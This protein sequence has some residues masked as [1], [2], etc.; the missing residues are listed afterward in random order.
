[1]AETESWWTDGYPNVELSPRRW[2]QVQ[3]EFLVAGRAGDRRRRHANPVQAS[4]PRFLRH[5]L[6]HGIVNGRIGH[7]SAFAD[8]VAPGFELRFDERDH[9]GVRQQEGRQRR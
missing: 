9:I 3:K 4:S 6:N 2:F 5:L 8:L 1:S 7:Q